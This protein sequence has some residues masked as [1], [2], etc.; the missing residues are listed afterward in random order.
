MNLINKFMRDNDSLILESLYFSILNEAI[1][2]RQVRRKKL[3]REN[4]GAYRIDQLN[5]AFKG[6]DRLVYDIQVFSKDIINLDFPILEKI[7]DILK[8]KLPDYTIPTKKSYVSGF[9]YKKEDTELK[10]PLKI[11]KILSKYQDDP[12]VSDVLKAFTHDPMRASTKNENLKVVISRHPYDV[13]GMSTDRS[14]TSCMNMGTEGVNYPSQSEGINRRFITND[15]SSGTIV[16]YL[17]SNNDRHENG[18]IAIK[19]PIARLLMKPYI[20][21]KNPNNHAYSVERV[22]GTPNESFVGFVRNWADKN[23]N[24]DVKDKRFVLH[25]GLYFDGEPYKNFVGVRKDIE[26]LSNAFFEN[27]YN[28][29]EEYFRNFII[30]TSS[31]GFTV[32]VIIEFSFDKEVEMQDIA[33]DASREKLPNYV[34]QMVNSMEIEESGSN[35]R[36][37]GVYIGRVE[38]NPEQENLVRIE[39]IFQIPDIRGDEYDEEYYED[40]PYIK[41][42]IVETFGQFM[43]E[44]GFDDFDYIKTYKKIRE[45]LLNAN[46]EIEKSSELEELKQE[47]LIVSDVNNPNSPLHR[48]NN[49]YQQYVDSIEAYQIA[50]EKLKNMPPIFDESYSIEQMNQNVDN[51]MDKNGEFVKAIEDIKKFKDNY[52]KV[53]D[54]MKAYRPSQSNYSLIVVQ[55]EWAKMVYEQVMGISVDDISKTL[56]GLKD[57]IFKFVSFVRIYSK[58]KEQQP[59]IAEKFKNFAYTFDDDFYFRISLW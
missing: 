49:E 6:K 28:T 59:E 37:S 31:D 47:F 7:L 50:V 39:Y 29:S 24:K 1:P 58:T 27:L 38:L 12:K 46:P 48:K 35:W 43:Q 14:W 17:I 51:A 25:S 41:D 40:D 18:K 13:A 44:S 21:T 4:S 22:Y 10:R 8:E 52:Q 9:I 19:R 16:A 3:T 33:Y 56:S 30:N 36:S 32:E 5:T 45:I 54:W 57:K 26:D 2:L 55:N 42:Y 23:I 20:D 11:T 15:I 34:Q 53:Y